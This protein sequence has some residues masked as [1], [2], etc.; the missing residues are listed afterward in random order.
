M[1]LGMPNLPQDWSNEQ[2]LGFFRLMWQQWLLKSGRGNSVDEEAI[3]G[4]APPAAVAAAGKIAL[5]ALGNVPAEKLFR[6]EEHEKTAGEGPP[7]EPASS[8]LLERSDSGTVHC[9]HFSND[10]EVDII[11]PLGRH[12]KSTLDIAS[13]S[14]VS[15]VRGP[16]ENPERRNRN[17]QWLRHHF[18]SLNEIGKLPFNNADLWQLHQFYFSP[19]SNPD[20]E[21]DRATSTESVEGDSAC[22]DRVPE[23]GVAPP[24]TP[25][26]APKISGLGRAVSFQA[27]GDALAAS[28]MIQPNP[29]HHKRRSDA[30]TEEEDG[31]AAKRVKAV[32]KP[33][34]AFYPRVMVSGICVSLAF[35]V[36]ESP[37]SYSQCMTRAQKAKIQSLGTKP[38][39]QSLS[40]LRQLKY[41]ENVIFAG[42]DPYAD[43]PQG[44]SDLACHADIEMILLDLL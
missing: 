4:P 23:M 8:A 35:H 21:G 1:T 26:I 33:R 31:P 20:S 19:P 43:I 2:V 41:T 30:G 38:M 27:L 18:R 37:T 25:A 42:R 34:I 7:V 29:N 39:D 5:S 28:G 3:K 44:N 13:S 40:L 14:K 36:G 16:L 24:P 32:S 10:L 22:E 11:E 9:P 12:T 17:L 15:T 6:T